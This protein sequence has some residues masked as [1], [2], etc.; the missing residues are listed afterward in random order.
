[1]AG[2]VINQDVS[3]HEKRIKLFLCF[4]LWLWRL[5]GNRNQQTYKYSRPNL[6]FQIPWIFPIPVS[7]SK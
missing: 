6:L 7:R 1:L 3:R 4:N 5:W 2:I